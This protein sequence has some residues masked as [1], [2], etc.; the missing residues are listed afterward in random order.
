MFHTLSGLK[1]TG[2]LLSRLLASAAMTGLILG[3]TWT[4]LAESKRPNVILIMTDD[5]GY[6]DFG[7]TGNPVIQTPNIDALAGQSAQ[8]KRFYVSPVCS[9]T[10][11]CLM[12]G[13]YN[14]RTRCIDTYIGRSMMEPEEIT[15]AEALRE[16]GY[17]TGIFGKWHLG[18]CYPMRPTDQ[19]FDEAWVLRGGGIG[20]PSDPIGAESKYTDP[21]LFH[22]NQPV[23][24]QGY[25]TDVY[26]DK[27]MQ[28]ID[29]SV[30]SEKPFFVYL[31]D[32]CPHGPFGDV[33]EEEYE[34]YKAMKLGNDQFPQDSGHLL[35]ENSNEDK[36]ARIFAMISNVDKNIG[37]LMERLD[38]QGIAENTIVIFMTDN[39]PNGMRY[40]AGMK[41]MKSHV[42]EAGIRT[43][44]LMRW[45]A[46]LKAGTSSDRLAAHIDVFP[47]LLAAC[48]ASL[49]EGVQ[50]DGRNFLPLLTGDVAA[51]DWEDRTLVI[52]SHRGNSPVR[53]HHFAAI[54]QDWK[55]VHPSGFGRENFEGD[56]KFELYHLKT[57][58]LE[59]ENI[60]GEQPE[61]LAEIKA[62][63]DRWFDD[64]S[65][66]RPDNYAPPG[67]V[68]GA[69]AAPVTTLTRQDWR[70]VSG[71]NWG[72][73]SMGYWE[74]E[75]VAAGKYQCRVYLN[76]G[77]QGF[78]GQLK[79]TIGNRQWVRQVDVDQ[80]YVDFDF[81]MTPVDLGE[82]QTQVELNDGKEAFGAYQVVLTHGD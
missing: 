57:D 40:K 28:F 79:L 8:M 69:G 78:E 43:P 54:S 19:G 9:P 67:I 50:Q 53:Y 81:W 59:M 36:R 7:F 44:F 42:H 11:A 29:Q 26:Y 18:D 5:Q 58:P 74:T 17:R 27:A 49:P 72:A 37:R 77:V 34:K 4:S 13:R 6:G 32:N 55:L 14:Y 62:V 38:R 10:R 23:Q 1:K 22:N 21:I 15:I 75:W 56:P 16:S 47:T 33:P 41:G 35:P 65:S 82:R 25:C 48:G 12:T 46:V 70:H 76:R 80:G 39:G 68:I 30:E 66:T 20:Q 71:Q 63:Y 51:C 52:Q 31:P 64:V 60:A 61:K 2:H 73:K 3:F 45:P 24:T